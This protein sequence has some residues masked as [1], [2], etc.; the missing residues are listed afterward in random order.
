MLELAIPEYA[1]LLLVIKF[2][3]HLACGLNCD[4]KDKNYNAGSATAAEK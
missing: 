1:K 4:R 2:G 3:L